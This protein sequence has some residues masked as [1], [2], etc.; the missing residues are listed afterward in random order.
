MFN[1]Y[2][3]PANQIII[4]MHWTNIIAHFFFLRSFPSPLLPLDIIN[5]FSC[6]LSETVF[7]HNGYTC[8]NIS[9]P[10]PHLPFQPFW[11]R[12]RCSCAMH[13]LLPHGLICG[14][15]N[16]KYFPKLLSLSLSLL[17]HTHT[18]CPFSS[19]LNST[20]GAGRL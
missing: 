7:P 20:S 9:A 6:F 17:V 2:G 14:V 15:R 18:P 13:P 10:A 1:S 3:Y 16:S 5:I 11:N 8:R 19:N 12:R 4:F